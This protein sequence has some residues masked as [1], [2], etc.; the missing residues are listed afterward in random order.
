MIKRDSI[1]RVCLSRWEQVKVRS[2]HLWRAKRGMA[3]IIVLGCL[4]FLSALVLGFMTSVTTELVSAK[5]YASGTSVRLLADS[6]VNI[7]MAQIQEA[8]SDPKMAWASQPGMIRTFDNKGVTRRSYKLYS[9]PEMLIE[10][11]YD[12][13]TTNAPT[14]VPFDWN[15]G[16]N[17]SRFVDLNAPLTVR[18]EKLYPIV[19]PVP[20][21][22]VAGFWAESEFGVAMPVQWLYVMKDGKIGQPADATEENPI[23]GR[24]AF[25]ADDETC[26]INLNTAAGDEWNAVQEKQ[27]GAYWDVPR[28]NN[29]FEK[30]L[31]MSQP[32]QGEYQR[33]PGHPATTFLSAV[34]PKRKAE[35]IY[36]LTPMYMHGGTLGGTRFI[37][38]SLPDP[39]PMRPPKGRLYT[40]VDELAFST[41]AIERDGVI[42][43]K[44]SLISRD[45]VDNKKFFLTAHSRASEL[46]LWNKPRVSVWPVHDTEDP[47]KRT[48]YDNLMVRAGTLGSNKYNKYY[49]S[50]KNPDSATEDYDTIPRNQEVYKYLL[51]LMQRDIPGFGGKFSDSGK[52][53]SN[54]DYEQIL[55]QIFDYIRCV[56][57]YDASTQTV[58]K[59]AQDG[60]VVPIEINAPTS[61][62]TKGFGRF[63]SIAQA[64]ML[65]YISQTNAPVTN[66]SIIYWTNYMRAM[67][68][69]TP[70]VV[71]HGFAEM[72]KSDYSLEVDFDLGL[73]L[74]PD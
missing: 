24:M 69:F 17:K 62:V 68:M 48:P 52:W 50:R 49:F 21:D 25:W 42:L 10:G 38:P 30:N 70:H 11:N 19:A 57:I 64:A 67:F 74:M 26:K 60:I 27:P 6:A 15:R 2:Q 43:R 61:G 1:R 73:R 23:V 44:P 32:Y 46:N 63:P 29:Q 71:S 16:E 13:G 37:V 33:Y 4:V 12:I 14:D 45:E 41:N 55:T 40:T 72:R 56:N 22:E 51:D 65:L 59:F 31:A 3:L 20:K 35:E 53:G 18:G 7:V 36:E 5:S 28:V 47:R 54:G 39:G 66:S 34:F 9:S 58:D 8:T